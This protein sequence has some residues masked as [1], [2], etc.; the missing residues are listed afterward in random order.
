MPRLLFLVRHG[1]TDW[2]EQGRL[3]GRCEVALNDRGR[4][5][6]AALA[7]ALRPFAPDRLIASPQRRAR[8]TAEA[9]GQVC[10]LATHVEADIDEVW[11]GRWQG[12]TFAELHDDPDVHAYL[13]DPAHQ[14]DAVESLGSLTARTAATAARLR[15]SDSRATVLVS[16]GDPLRALLVALL[17]M[18]PREFRAFS[19]SPGSVSVVRLGRRRAQLAALSWRPT[20]LYD[21]IQS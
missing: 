9:I 15:E 18:A 16:H 10:G 17:A 2:N 3:L 12:K 6:A 13:G 4:A 11:L 7:T 14:C 21:L 8:E 1:L 19:V 5:Q 20:D